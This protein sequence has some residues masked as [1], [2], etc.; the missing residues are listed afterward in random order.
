M[1][2]KQR[3]TYNRTTNEYA[4]IKVTETEMMRLS[5]MSTRS[6][7]IRN[8]ASAVSYSNKHTFRLKKKNPLYLQDEIN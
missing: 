7:T 1:H 8:R 2:H 3:T 5:M 6:D 4:S